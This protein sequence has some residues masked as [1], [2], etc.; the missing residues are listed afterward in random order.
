MRSFLQKRIKK[1]MSVKVL[2]CSGVSVF[3]S[4]R[5]E[6]LWD[7]GDPLGNISNEA[8]FLFFVNMFTIE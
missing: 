1:C 7:K 5:S 3:P 8:M 6:A 2:K 4:L